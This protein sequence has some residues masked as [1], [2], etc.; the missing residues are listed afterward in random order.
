[1]SSPEARRGLRRPACEKCDPGRKKTARHAQDR[2]AK[3]KLVANCG[4]G[5]NKQSEDESW[6]RRLRSSDHR[7][8]GRKRD[9]DD[10]P[11]AGSSE[12]GAAP[13]PRRDEARTW[14]W[15]IGIAPGDADLP[16]A[17]FCDRRLHADSH[18]FAAFEPRA[19]Q[20]RAAPK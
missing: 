16:S 10:E 8:M 1:M 11:A 5:C 3:K 15:C 20:L 4:Q 9:C 17:P 7:A 6:G 14:R 19:R 2:S 13:N 12:H 18:R